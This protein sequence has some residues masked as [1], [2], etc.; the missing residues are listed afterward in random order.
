MFSMIVT[1]RLIRVNIRLYTYVRI[2][3]RNLLVLYQRT[4]LTC[5]VH[6]CDRE[7]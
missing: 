7:T 2:T 4:G 1:V 3:L 5:V 6:L